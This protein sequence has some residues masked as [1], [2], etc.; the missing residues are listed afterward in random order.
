[1]IIPSDAEL[2]ELPHTS[3]QYIDDLEALVSTHEE[4][5][6]SILNGI[7]RIHT[8][9]KSLSESLQDKDIIV[10]DLKLF[11]SSIYKKCYDKIK[12]LIDSKGIILDGTKR[13]E[14]SQEK[15]AC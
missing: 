10:S 8:D 4:L 1:M 9:S 14:T 13:Q 12:I 7:S 6:L 11:E 5:L 3:K 15:S 2:A